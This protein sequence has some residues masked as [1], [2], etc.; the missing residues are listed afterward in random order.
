[1]TT[2]E[3]RKEYLDVA[4]MGQPVIAENREYWIRVEDYRN[5]AA[6][7]DVDWLEIVVPFQI[8][9]AITHGASEQNKLEGRGV[10]DIKVEIPEKNQTVWSR[11][12]AH[13]HC[14][15][16]YQSMRE[17]KNDEPIPA[18]S[19]YF[20]QNIEALKGAIAGRIVRSPK[21]LI[22]QEV[23]VPPGTV[24]TLLRH[25]D[26]EIEAFY[27]LKEIG[28]H[29]LNAGNIDD[30]SKDFC[31]WFYEVCS[32]NITCPS[33]RPEAWGKTQRDR[34]T[35]AL[36]VELTNHGFS[37]TRGENNPTVSACD[38][39]SAAALETRVRGLSSYETVR[40]IYQRFQKDNMGKITK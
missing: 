32:G 15:K 18:V 37:A 1:M 2:H 36:I 28:L 21:G 9:H 35:F 22:G 29:C 20:T 6:P 39:V 13:S 40:K 19:N 17:R 34:L 30:Q 27:F 4:K 10:I 25:A 33:R 11:E 14:I 24:Q 7:F 8:H 23:F 12:Q 3:V 26:R 38:V 16:Q 31:S 5:R